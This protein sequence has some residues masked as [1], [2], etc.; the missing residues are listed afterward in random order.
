M[1]EFKLDWCKIF[2]RCRTAATAKASYFIAFLESLLNSFK[3]YANNK[4]NK[5]RSTKL[6][7]KQLLL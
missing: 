4:T 1:S 2:E 6:E 7:L 3:F 5:K